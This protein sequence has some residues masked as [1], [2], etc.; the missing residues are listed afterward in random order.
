MTDELARL[1]ERHG[2]ATSYFDAFGMRREA[3]ARSLIALLAELG[4]QPGD[5]AQQAA[6]ALPAVVVVQLPVAGWPVRLR[7]APSV[8][9]VHWRIRDERGTVLE[10]EGDVGAD[11]AAPRERT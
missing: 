9:R 2:I 10:G 5:D 8:R 1:C 4:V 7:L 11:E 3:S 6:R